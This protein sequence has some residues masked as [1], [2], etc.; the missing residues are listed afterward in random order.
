MDRVTWKGCTGQRSTVG[1]GLGVLRACLATFVDT[2][3]TGQG[4]NTSGGDQ[5]TAKCFLGG[6]DATTASGKNIG[7]RTNGG[8][9]HSPFCGQERKEEKQKKTV[10]C[11]RGGNLAILRLSEKSS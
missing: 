9:K 8:T 3:N 7:T 2:F 1:W 6:G 5:V 11:G 10:P 4:E